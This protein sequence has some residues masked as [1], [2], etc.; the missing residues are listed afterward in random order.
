[1]KCLFRSHLISLGLVSNSGFH[2]LQQPGGSQKKIIRIINYD[3]IIIIEH[4][5]NFSL[6]LFIT[7]YLYLHGHTVSCIN[8][9]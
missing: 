4:Y 7:N 8:S 2:C 9:A 5:H 3:H 1:M 6:L